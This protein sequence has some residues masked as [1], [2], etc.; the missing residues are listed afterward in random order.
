LGQ[1]VLLGTSAAAAG[2]LMGAGVGMAAWPIFSSDPTEVHGPLEVPLA[3]LL[4]VLVLG[5]L[6]AVMAALFPSRGLGKL[7][8][9]AAL[10]GSA[11]SSAPSRRAPW[12]GLVL[13]IGGGASTWASVRLQ[14]AY[15]EPSFYVWL[16]A[17]VVTV[18]GALLLV[19]ALLLLA[20]RLAGAAPVVLRMA[21]RDIARQR[22]RATAT[23]A[24]IMGGALLLGTIWTLIASIDADAERRY[25]PSMPYGHGRLLLDER[26]KE[27]AQRALVGVEPTL[28]T[29]VLSSVLGW[30][31]TGTLED[32][33]PPIAIRPGCPVP[34]LDQTNI[35]DRCRSLGA[36]GREIIAGRVQDLA[37]LF[38][39]NSDQV[40]ALRA[41]TML[42]DTDPIKSWNGQGTNELIDGHL[43]LAFTP[44]EAAGAPQ[45]LRVPALAV[46]AA[47]I[48]R[49]AVHSRV[50]ALISLEAAASHHLALDDGTVHVL[51]ASGPISPALEARINTAL[52]DGYSRI[53]VERGFE[54]AD[55]LPTWAV[56]GTLA[57]LAVITAAM[58]TI[59]ATSDLRP[60]LATLN[61]VGASPHLGRRLATTTA[62]VLGALGTVLGFGIGYVVGSPLALTLTEDAHEGVPPI[63]VLPWAIGVLFSVVVALC[64]AV[65]AAVCVPTRP[66]LTQRTT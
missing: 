19:P 35:E 61:A 40:T 42:V 17:V 3:F 27:E 31:S 25:L 59:L 57:V 48:D 30:S 44:S 58:A 49:G 50:G 26:T 46:N 66:V 14:D 15:G 22:G 43:H 41:G 7:D 63:L 34:T 51:D 54:P 36:D 9:V 60:F 2:T 23:V 12:W 13:L 55:Q 16:A 62:A 29:A 37:W 33:A 45:I 39:L 18:A 53:K 56:T 28:R 6:T 47:L 21:L 32:A 65:V 10:R 52:N 24:A 4:G 38:D 64:A 1:S 5:I 8:L 20:A 11:R